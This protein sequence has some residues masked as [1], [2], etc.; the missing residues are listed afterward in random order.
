MGAIYAMQG[1]GTAINNELKTELRINAKDAFKEAVNYRPSLGSAWVNLALLTLAEGKELGN[2]SS[3]QSKVENT[4]KEAR[5]CCERALGLDNDDEQ[6]RALA[7]KLV[8][9]IDSMMKQMRKL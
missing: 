6:S 7:N 3:E 5:Q 1:K 8:V 2:S 4:L 9:D